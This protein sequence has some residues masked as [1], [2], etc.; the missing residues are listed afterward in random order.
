MHITSSTDTGEGQ[1]MR[2]IS[3]SFP[4]GN[5][6]FLLSPF[7]SSLFSPLSYSSLLIYVRTYLMLPISSFSRRTLS[8]LMSSS[9][10]P[11]TIVASSR[12]ALH[13][14]HLSSSNN[15]NYTQTSAMA[16]EMTPVFAKDAAPRMFIQLLDFN[17]KIDGGR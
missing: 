7:P 3:Q 8:Q 6:I 14:S 12:L 13:N 2:R 15:R 11:A 1:P 9:I 5:F 16:A 10:R 4:T 17:D